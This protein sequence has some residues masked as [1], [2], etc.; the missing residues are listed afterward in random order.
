MGSSSSRSQATLWHKWVTE[1]EGKSCGPRSGHHSY[2]DRVFYHT[3]DGERPIARFVKSPTGRWILFG[4]IGR[5]WSGRRELP[6]PLL[7]TNDIG[8]Q[9]MLVNSDQEFISEMGE[10]IRR[11]LNFLLD[12]AGRRSVTK[13]IY[14]G[15]H[16]KQMLEHLTRQYNF[17]NI[18]FGKRWPILPDYE[19]MIEKIL[20]RRKEDYEA[21]SDKREKEQAYREK[22]KLKQIA[23]DHLT[24]VAA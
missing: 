7:M 19:A 15:Y 12:L 18:E 17:V 8:A 24:G 22:R 1:G 5:Y 9:G 13:G 14:I 21:R 2:I 23:Y 20:A 11:Q 10:S 6:F 16:T 3:Y 4:L